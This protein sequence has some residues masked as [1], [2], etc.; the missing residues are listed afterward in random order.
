MKR[1]ITPCTLSV[2]LV[3]GAIAAIS[4][5]GTNASATTVAS[6]TPAHMRA[7][8]GTSEGAAG[9]IYVALVF[10]NTGGTC[11]IWGVPSVQPVLASR[12]PVGPPARNQ[13]MGAMG[14]R[15]VVGTG[16][17][18]SVAFGVTQTANYPASACVARAAN[19]V[20]VSLGTFVR[21]TYLRL[22][23]SVCNKRASTTT[24]LIVAGTTGS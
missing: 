10:T 22:A 7:S 5:S 8:V 17:S 9:T 1:K 11:A 3:L 23:I 24:R 6:C 13:S 20:V 15:H 16:R 12:R 2:S 14:V 18:V 21:P 4:F 19:G